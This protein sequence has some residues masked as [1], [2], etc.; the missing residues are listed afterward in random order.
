MLWNESFLDLHHRC[1]GFY[2]S[3]NPDFESYYNET[4][5]AFLHT[6]GCQRREFF[7]FVE[8]FC[9]DNSPTPGTAL[10]VAAVRRDYFLNVQNAASWDG[11]LLTRDDIP[12]F[13]EALDAIAYLPRIIAK[14]RA[15]LRG[16]LDPDLMFCCG[17]DRNFLR[18]HGNLDPAD[19]LRAVWSAGDDDAAIATWVRA[20]M[21]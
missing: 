14:A 6:I 9:E 21:H 17:G 12:S 16:A 2:R 4:D 15:K 5:L 7:D 20:Q 8:D 10:L 3:G 19:F 13:G 11:P 18:K 1:V